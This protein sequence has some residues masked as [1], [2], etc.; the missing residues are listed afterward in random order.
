MQFYIKHPKAYYV[1][2]IQVLYECLFLL[3]LLSLLLLTMQAT[4]R[5]YANNGCICLMA[6]THIT[7]DYSC[8]AHAGTWSSCS[9]HTI[10]LISVD[11][12]HSAG[13]N[14]DLL[15]FLACTYLTPDLYFLKSPTCTY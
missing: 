7:V 1:E 12:K 2:R 6:D 5:C 10:F 3:L 15:N 4:R 11:T 14:G 9:I 13:L 8:T